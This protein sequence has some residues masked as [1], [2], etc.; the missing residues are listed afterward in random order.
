MSPIRLPYGKSELWLE[1]GAL[2]VKAV[3]EPDSRLPQGRRTVQEALS[4]PIGT[5]RL[6]LLCRD[7]KHLLLITSDHTRPLPSKETLPPILEEARRY[8]PELEIKILVATGCHRGMTESEM[9][10]RFGPELVERETIINHDAFQSDS[11]VYKGMLPSGGKLLL[12]NLVDWADLVAAEGFIEP[13][14]FAGFSGG[15]KSILPGIAAGETVYGNHCAKFISSESARTG[16]LAG[17]PI[18]EDMV[19]AARQAGLAFI[20]N[21]VLDHDKKMIAAFAGDPQQAH[22]EGCQ[23]VLSLFRVQPVSADIVVTTNGGYPL[24]QNLYQAV[25]G[26]TAAEQC[27]VP[28]GVVIMLAECADGHGGD[29]FFH[30][31]A[32]GKAPQ[33]ILEEICETAM[34]DTRA[35]QWQ[36]QILARVLCKCTVIMVTREDNRQLVERMGMQFAH[37]LETAIAAAKKIAGEQASAVVIPDGVGIILEAPQGA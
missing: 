37:N 13:H 21:V 19:F 25:K 7:I 15:R 28:G 23:F 12:N 30:W 35:D 29:H 26:L 20:L 9:M 22:G 36:V 18:H 4:H 33:A 1:S 17:N 27:V 10:D 14:F 8:N 34:E 2:P 24:D 3:L 32:S 16:N 11:M 31:F 5:Q 6:C